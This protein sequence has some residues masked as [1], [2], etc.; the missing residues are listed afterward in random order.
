MKMTFLPFKGVAATLAGI[1]FL[2]LFV[3]Q[4][5]LA[6]PVDPFQNYDP[7][8]PDPQYDSNPFSQN[9]DQFSMFQMIHNANF[10]QLNPNFAVEQ[11]QQMDDAI[12][13]YQKKQ[14]LR[15]QQT[16]QP[17]PNGVQLTQPRVVVPLSGQ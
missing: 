9:A 3:T 17:Q 7:Q 10:G 5:T 1:G 6:N 2:S 12:S 13:A 15:L 4:P 8:N 16:Q 14:Q 11:N